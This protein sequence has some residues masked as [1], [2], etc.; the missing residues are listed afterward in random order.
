[1]E[2][3]RVLKELRSGELN[4]VPEFDENGVLVLE[5]SSKPV[6]FS[7]LFRLKTSKILIIG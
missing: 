3:E 4:E 5:Y 7:I 1:M 2:L 6:W